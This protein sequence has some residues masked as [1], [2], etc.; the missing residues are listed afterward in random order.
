MDAV[1]PVLGYWLALAVVGAGLYAL[2][3]F[4]IWEFEETPYEYLWAWRS[5]VDHVV[6]IYEDP[7]Y[8]KAVLE[9]LYLAEKNG[10]YTDR[11][12]SRRMLANYWRIL[13]LN[14]F[15]LYFTLTNFS[16]LLLLA[17]GAAV[18]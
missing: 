5:Q 2:S 8:K 1:Y 16:C 12:V 17:F 9:Q 18:S 10:D 4:R 11:P 15:A 13:E 6:L 7:A 14:R 3:F